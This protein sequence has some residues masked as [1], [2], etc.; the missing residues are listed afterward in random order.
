MNQAIE[1]ITGYTEEELLDET[2]TILQSGMHGRAFYKKMWDSLINEGGWEGEVFNRKKN[3]ELYYQW[4]KIIVI[5]DEVGG[6]KNFISILSDI[7]KEKELEKEMILTSQIQQRLLPNQISTEYFKTKTF[8]R[9]KM[10]VSGDFFDYV[11][12]EEKAKL[13]GILIDFKGHGFS[14]A[15]LTPAMQ[16]LFKK[17]IQEDSLL[18]EKVNRLNHLS[19]EYFSED[20]FAAVFCFEIDFERAKL[21][22]VSAGINHFVLLTAKS[23]ELVEVPG[24]F[25][26]MSE[27]QRYQ[28]QE[29]NIN[30][31]DIFYFMTDGVSDIIP[32]NTTW[33][34][35][36]L[37]QT[38]D[39]LLEIIMSNQIRDDET[40]FG[41]EVL[42]SN[43][44]V[45]SLNETFIFNDVEEFH[46]VKKQVKST[47]D[48]LNITDKDLL[49]MAL[50]EAVNNAWL[51]GNK[52]AKFKKIS[53]TVKVIK[54]N[55]IIFRI[56]DQ[57]QG[58]KGNEAVKKYGSKIEEEFEKRIFDE[59]GRGLLI[60]MKVFDKVFYNKAGNELLLVKHFI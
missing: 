43:K 49:C 60:M 32:K 51:H 23:R 22:Y 4:L 31:G 33:K 48:Y 35:K 26:G 42:K 50:V 20:T 12:V 58:F 38:Y 17:V 1:K 56:K 3:K 39:Q 7:T 55:K 52:C 9:P 15:L 53:F 25:L 27:D 54:T 44:S 37:E 19:I 8:Y 11:W 16:V 40:F 24:L 30:K 46:L 10:F 13:Y 59:S 21:A 6:I 28:K 45:N 14:A 5:K 2:P 47:L 41:V 57:G 34:G 18:E 36:G 29:I